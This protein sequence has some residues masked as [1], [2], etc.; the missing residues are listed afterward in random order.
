[1]RLI[2][3]R[4]RNWCQLRDLTVQFRPGLNGILGRNGRG[5]SNTLDALRFAFTGESV[6]H[7]NKKDNLTWGEESGWVVVCFEV[8]DTI[9]QLKRSIESP[10]VELKWKDE[11]L[12]SSA[13][14]EK[15]LTRLLAN[16]KT[17][18]DNVFIPQGKIDAILCSRSSDRL[19]DFQE[20]FGL[21]RAADAHRLLTT[22]INNARLTPGLEHATLQAI[23]FYKESA[24]QLKVLEGQIGSIKNCIAALMPAEQ[25]LRQSLEAT[26]TQG[27]IRQADLNLTMAADE[28]EGCSTRL[29]GAKLA[30]DR[31]ASTVTTIR[32]QVEQLAGE[33]RDLE[34]QAVEFTHAEQLRANLEVISRASR[35]AAVGWLSAIDQMTPLEEQLAQQTKH[36]S[37]LETLKDNP[38]ARP[39]FPGEQEAIDQ[40]QSAQ[41]LLRGLQKAQKSSL[42]VKY[43]QEMAH[44]KT[45]LGAFDKGV[46]PT[47]GQTVHGGPEAAKQRVTQIETLKGLIEREQATA[48]AETKQ[49]VGVVETLKQTVKSFEEASARGMAGMIREAEEAIRSTKQSI[50][51][52][53]LTIEE[54]NK[55]AASLEAAERSLKGAPTVKP[56][57][58]RIKAI[59]SF[60]DQLRM[61]EQELVGLNGQVEIHRGALN[62]ATAQLNQA[63]QIRAQ[64]GET[65]QAPTPEQVKEAQQQAIE[66]FNKRVLLDQ[67]L[68]ELGVEQAKFSQREAE[69]NRLKQ[70]MGQEAKLAGWIEQAK[71]AKDVLHVTQLPALVMREFARVINRQV[72]YYLETWEAG[73]RMWLDD[74]LSF[75]VKF[76]DGKELEAARLSGGQKVVAATSFRLAMSD[77]FARKVGLLVLDEP[78]NHLDK[79]NIQH[80]QA[81]LLHLKQ[82]STHSGRQILIVTHEDSLMGFLDHVVEIK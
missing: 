15:E 35:V 70:L 20:A 54:A 58:D 24:D 27:A 12:T 17:L 6:N 14:V 9:Y 10:R 5:K 13:A 29:D 18:H 64:L 61:A 42:Q 23:E 53:Q 7:G 45:E 36:L 68:Q 73:Y 46:C 43:E 69:A 19:K 79:D 74:S 31:L 50:V 40:L 81:L 55:A 75:R 57:E 63:K 2:E 59:K 21:D 77:T 11:K 26:R 38:A 3:L 33:L 39:K 71:K 34:R 4:L 56:S 82:M 65:V 1:M 25:V 47:C 80:L 41:E 22:E 32:P 28:V 8:G 78:S 62:G 66:L 49:Q 72:E 37:M 51:P 60:Q 52:L 48:L 44:L 67:A 16:P 30:A 76:D